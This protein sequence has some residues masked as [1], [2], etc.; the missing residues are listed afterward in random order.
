MVGLAVELDRLRLES[1]TDIAE[2]QLH[3]V[4][5]GP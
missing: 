3:L 5:Y 2:D 1:G 4:E